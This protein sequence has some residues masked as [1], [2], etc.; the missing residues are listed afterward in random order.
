MTATGSAASP[1]PAWG[2]P[3]TDPDYVAL[4]RCWISPEFA[5]RA[6]L[7]RVTSVDGAEI[8]GR[9]NNGS[10]DGLTF[11]YLWPGEDRIR[12]YWLRRDRP[13]IEHDAEGDPKEKNKYLGP[14]GRGNLL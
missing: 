8:V 4:E 1:R 12:E 14:P 7:R 3:L 5:N 2:G 10:Y 13:D 11:P 6:L 9:R